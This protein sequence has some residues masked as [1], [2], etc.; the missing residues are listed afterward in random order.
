M[1]YK[2]EIFLSQ[3]FMCRSSP[4]PTY[5]HLYQY[6][7]MNASERLGNLAIDKRRRLSH[8]NI[9]SPL[10][11]EIVKNAINLFDTKDCILEAFQN[12]DVTA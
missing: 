3:R 4:L 8:S 1:T 6:T 11:I 12:Q 5:H 2:V 9:F 7:I 10:L